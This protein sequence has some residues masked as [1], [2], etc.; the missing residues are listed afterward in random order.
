MT[1]LWQVMRFERLNPAMWRLKRFSTKQLLAK[2]QLPALRVIGVWPRHLF[3]PH[4]GISIDHFCMMS[5][6]YVMSPL[7]TLGV[8]VSLDFLRV[9]FLCRCHCKLP[10]CR[11]K[12]RTLVPRHSLRKKTNCSKQ[13]PLTV[14][15]KRLF[16][17]FL[18][19]NMSSIWTT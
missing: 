8:Y 4:F 2:Q 19:G 5:H 15:S 12:A 9:F 11:D 7:Q 18:P 3:P 13:S 16:K 6:T 1:L 10:L 17:Q 14:Y